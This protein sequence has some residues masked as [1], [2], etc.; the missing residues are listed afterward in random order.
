MRRAYA[1]LRYDTS[2][3]IPVAKKLAQRWNS[4]VGTATLE[5]SASCPHAL[6]ASTQS[7]ANRHGHRVL[8]VAF[9]GPS[10]HANT[11]RAVKVYAQLAVVVIS[12]IQTKCY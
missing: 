12:L 3:E 4:Q 7:E 10:C 2:E 6:A 1:S 9:V 8:Y 5:S 11:D